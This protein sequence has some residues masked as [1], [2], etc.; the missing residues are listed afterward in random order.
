MA[1]TPP[2]KT[3]SQPN[4]SAKSTPTQAKEHRWEELLHLVVVKNEEVER[5]WTALAA[6]MKREFLSVEAFDAHR[7]Y[8]LD[9]IVS[10]FKPSLRSIWTKEPRPTRNHPDYRRFENVRSKANYYFNKLKKIMFP[11]P[12]SEMSKEDKEV[13][14]VFNR[15][16]IK[17]E[18]KLL[19]MCED[20]EAI[21]REQAEAELEK[22]TKQLEANMLTREQMG[23]PVEGSKNACVCSACEGKGFIEQ[24]A[25]DA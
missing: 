15:L 24:E 1:T 22:N 23:I 3:H 21:A 11:K 25:D 6:I 13:A 19:K 4:S 14:F 8:I 2:T 9:V 12:F 7:K 10:G 18:E 17:D 5:E 16:S 20:T